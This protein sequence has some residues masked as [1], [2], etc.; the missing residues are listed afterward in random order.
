MNGA[1]TSNNCKAI[2]QGLYESADWGIDFLFCLL[3]LGAE[4][5]LLVLADVEITD[6]LQV[7]SHGEQLL[8]CLP[9]TM[10][11]DES[12]FLLHVKF[13]GFFD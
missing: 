5:C 13:L 1:L 2:L 10:L 12:H 4:G 3:V 11:L 6:A 7:N 8:R 9:F